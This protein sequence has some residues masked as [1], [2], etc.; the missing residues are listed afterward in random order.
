[1][2]Q[3]D[4]L[5]GVP[6]NDDVLEISA[7]FRHHELDTTLRMRPRHNQLAWKLTLRHGVGKLHPPVSIVA[8]KEPIHHVAEAEVAPI[9]KAVPDGTH[10][11]RTPFA[12]DENKFVPKG[13]KS[14]LCTL[15]DDHVVIVGPE[16][17]GW[18]DGTVD[19]LCRNWIR[20]GALLDKV[21]IGILDER[22]GHLQ[23]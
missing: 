15:I 21:T 17:A 11:R 19:V 2:S 9:V 16:R 7:V 18:L 22:D 13:A 6:V 14:H 8:K 3:H 10:G 20:H 4:D 1:M 12:A 5:V 23:M